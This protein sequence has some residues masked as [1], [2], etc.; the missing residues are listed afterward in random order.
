[1][2]PAGAVRAAES[3]VAA[4]LWVVLCAG[5]SVLALTTPVFTSALTQVLGVPA[6]SGLSTE[7]VVRL[8]AS[9]RAL[10]ADAEYEPL[11]A[12]WKGAPAFDAAS[13]SHLLDVRS[14]ISGARVATGVAALMLAIYLATAIALRR[15][16]PLRSGMSVAA[17]GLVALVVLA[18][19]AAVLDFGTLFAWFHSLFFASG[20]WTFPADSLLIRLFPERFWVAAGASWAALILLSAAVLAAAGH[21]LVPALEGIGASRTAQNV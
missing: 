5:S 8:S 6:T 7:D 14:V 15:L 4:L 11:P 2:R 13:V 17:G 10:V 20:T 16:G 21:W 12:E 19:A 3:A 18:L 1:M 9:V